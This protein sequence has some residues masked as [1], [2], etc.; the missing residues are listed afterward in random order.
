LVKPHLVT[1]DCSNDGF[2][3]EKQDINC[4][5]CGHPMISKEYSFSGV[6]L[7]TTIHNTDHCRELAR[8][9]TNGCSGRIGD[10]F[11]PK[12]KPKAASKY[13]QTADP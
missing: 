5:A 9:I 3:G 1:F 8:Q 4:R 7:W 13:S 2:T 12:Q 10:S 11:K 6:S